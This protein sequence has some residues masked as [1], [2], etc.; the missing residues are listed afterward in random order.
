MAQR[1]E[2]INPRD[3]KVIRDAQPKWTPTPP[4]A[5][6]WYWMRGRRH[7]D[8][9]PQCVRVDDRLYVLMQGF[10][11]W[12]PAADFAVDWAGPLVPPE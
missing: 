6:G 4:T 10:I 3:A 9:L 1:H 5:P 12:H 7:D 8:N 11:E 2:W